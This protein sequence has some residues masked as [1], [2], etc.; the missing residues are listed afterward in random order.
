HE[1]YL[2]NALMDNVPDHIY[3]KDAEG[4]FTRINKAYAEQFG[5]SDPTQVVGKTDLDFL[6]EEHAQSAYEDEQEIIKSG[7]PMVKEE[8]YVWPDGR[9]TWASVVKLPLRDGKGRIVGAFGISRDITARK[10]AEEVLEKRALRLQT[11][12]E[13]SRTVSSILDPG[14]LISNV[15]DLIRERFDL[16]YAGLFLLDEVGDWAVLRAGTGEAGRQMLEQ[17]H[18]LE[19]GGESMIGWCVAH[20]QARIALDVGE[21]AVRFENPL[22]PETRSE[23]ALPLISRGK[24]VGALTIQSVREAAFDEEDVAVLQ[25]MAD[26]LANAIENARLAERTEAQLREME[27]LYGEYSAAAWADLLS[28]ERPLGYVYDRVDVRPVMDSLPPALDLAPRR[29]ESGTAADRAVTGSMLTMPLELRGQTIGVLG[30]QESEGVREWSSEEIAIV[31]AVSDQVAMALDSARLFGDARTRAEEMVVLNELAQSLAA[32]LAVE[33]VLEETF[34]GV[35]Q[36]LDT[37]NF[38]VALYDSETGHVSFP[39]ATEDGQRVQWR[40]RQVGEETGLT[41]YI[42]RTRQ[43]LLIH[44]NVSEWLKEMEIEMIGAV[45]RSW[46]GV[47][48]LVGDRVLGVVA[49]QSMTT[50]RAYGE[51]EQDLLTAVASQ[52]AIALQSVNLFQET[53]RKATQLA[54]AA[55]VARD[56]TAILDVDQLLDETV[57]LIS[58]QF[59]FYHAGVFLLDE[60]SRYAVLQAA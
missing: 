39:L 9:E 50:P 7:Q 24:V 3:F 52:T 17:S 59:G 37:T 54:A 28:P 49:V 19:I 1:Q 2:L 32:S 33:E 4:R 10:W 47:P 34:R 21:E 15:V 60:E 51:H 35:S 12:A 14:E 31:E 8:E 40:S 26:Q 45:A 6:T 58:E 38:Y 20:E 27:R 11:A 30:V 13:I 41:E 46:L 16:Y 18:K 48:L 5:L 36:L 43:P 44:E 53:Q 55:E 42:I 56:A 25:T 22:L 57:H 23:L 29:A